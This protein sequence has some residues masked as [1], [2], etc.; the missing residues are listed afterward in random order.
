MFPLSSTIHLTD[1]PRDALQ[2]IFRKQRDCRIA[3]PERSDIIINQVNPEVLEIRFEAIVVFRSDWELELSHKCELQLIQMNRKVELTPHSRNAKVLT[4]GVYLAS[5][6]TLRFDSD[7]IQIP[8]ET[9]EYV[10]T[11]K[12]VGS[13]TYYET[14]DFSVVS[15][16]TDLGLNYIIPKQ[17]ELELVL[18]E[19]VPLDAFVELILEPTA[20]PCR[21]GIYRIDSQGRWAKHIHQSYMIRQSLMETT[22]HVTY[23][24]SL[25]HG[26]D[27][28]FILDS[29]CDLKI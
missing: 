26:N 29:S 12:C 2:M 15:Y 6:A 18:P 20:K 14:N 9:V 7:T 8:I 24:P 21:L 16:G 10:E 25:W 23:Q 22:L 3:D 27:Q 1:L 13:L 17:I 5:E 28:R 11:L 4:Y 19:T